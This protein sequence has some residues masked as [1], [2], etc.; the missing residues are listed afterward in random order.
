MQRRIQNAEFRI[1]DKLWALHYGP[2]P[3]EQKK[4]TYLEFALI[5]EDQWLEELELVGR[6]PIQK[7]R[8]RDI[9][10]EHRLSDTLFHGNIFSALNRVC[11]VPYD[12]DDGRRKRDIPICLHPARLVAEWK[13]YQETT[14]PT[15]QGRVRWVESP[16]PG[17]PPTLSILQEM[18]F[19]PDDELKTQVWPIKKDR[20][21]PQGKVL[22]FRLGHRKQVYPT[23]HSAFVAAHQILLELVADLKVHAPPRP[24]I[25]RFVRKYPAKRYRIVLGDISI[26]VERVEK[27]S[28]LYR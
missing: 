15:I 21:L 17:P 19:F 10:D 4:R 3:S 8:I 25:E 18:G 5:G 23:F 11:F 24:T 27:M 9:I 16:H 14:V 7:R 1:P 22:G 2:V 12:G 6:K 13:Y 26:V 20:G 28:D